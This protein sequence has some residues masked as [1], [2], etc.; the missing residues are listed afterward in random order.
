LYADHPTYVKRDADQQLYEAVRAGE[1]CYVFNCRQMGKSSLQVR[2]ADQLESDGSG[3]RCAVL[4]LS[5]M[6]ADASTAAKWYRTVIGHLDRCLGLLPEQEL[7]QWLTAQGQVMPVY[8][9]QRFIEDVLLV[10]IPEDP[11]VIFIDEIDTVLS[12]SFPANDFFALIRAC[13]NQRSQ[14]PTYRRLTFVLLG[15]A[16]PSQLIRDKTRTPF[17]IGKAIELTPLAFDQAQCLAEGLVGWVADPQRVLA[18]VFEWTGGQPYLTQKLCELVQAEAQEA[19]DL[20]WLPAGQEATEVGRLVQEHLVAHWQN[21]ELPHFKTIQD[22]LLRHAHLTGR[23]LATYEQILQSDGVAVNDSETHG[24]LRLSGLVLPRAGQLQVYNRVYASIFDAG[25]V[26]ATLENLRPYGEAF[27]AWVRSGCRDESRLLRG[28]ALLDA[29]AWAR[30]KSLSELDERF[31]R[32]SQTLE[33]REIQSAMR[34]AQR[35]VKTGTGVLAMMLILAS[36][37]GVF[38]VIFGRRAVSFAQEAAQAKAEQEAA[39]RFGPLETQVSSWDQLSIQL[40]LNTARILQTDAEAK[41]ERAQQQAEAAADE[42]A[43][44]QAQ[45]D[46]AAAANAQLAAQQEALREEREILVAG[47][48]ELESD[49]ARNQEMLALV[50]EGIAIEQDVAPLNQRV[51]SHPLETYLRALEQGFR[52]KARNQELANLRG[53]ASLNDYEVYGPFVLLSRLQN[54]TQAP[55]PKDFLQLSGNNTSQRQT[56][57][58]GHWAVASPDG[59]TI[60]TASGDS[61]AKLWS[62]DGTLLYTLE[63]HQDWV[64]SAVF[65][66]DGQT[67]LTA[68]IDGTARLWSREGTLLTVLEGHQGAVSS[69]IF[70]PDGQLILTASID[71]NARVWNREGTLLNILEGHW[72]PVTSAVFSPDGQHIL[73]AS[74]DGARLWS[75]E[76]TLL[77]I[78]KGHWGPVTSAVFSPDG[79][80]ILTAS[81]NGDTR[82]WS[83]EGTLLNILERH[84]GPVTSA[85]FSSDGQHILT[86]SIDGNAHLWNREGTLLSTL[87][88]LSSIRSA[89]FSPDGQYILTASTDGR[90]RVWS[91]SGQ[92]LDSTGVVEVHSAIFSPDGQYVLT[93]STNGIARVWSSSGQFLDSTGIVEIRSAIFSPDGQYV[94]TTSEDGI[95]RVWS[96]DGQLLHALE[97]L[98]SIVRSAIF[99][100]DG[101]YVLTTSEDGTAKLWSRN[102]N[103]LHS[104]EDHQFAVYSAVFSPDGQPSSP[105]QKTAPPSSGA[106]TATSCTPSRTTRTR[107]PVRSLAPMARPSSPLQKTAP[108]SSGAATATSCTPSRTTSSGSTVRSL[109]PMANHPHRFRRRHRQALEPQRQPPALPRGPPVRGLQCG[110]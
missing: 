66:P 105:L 6:G 73:T 38:A 83:R 42:A 51:E 35:L 76:G 40:S 107:S 60:L 16:T 96:R 62:R 52:L 47:R 33:N 13:F 36:A 100:P 99:S 8:R 25:W 19:E 54:L 15:V 34:K 89:V 75:R 82:L 92:F 101:Q 68:S 67:I 50:Q 46:E 14:H 9:L 26:Q 2:I 24:E 23:L 3:T 102:G 64:N 77:N 29:V 41:A 12:L 65:S 56:L 90:V 59:Q 49:I 5:G 37:A 74:I 18:E 11:I 109:A 28:Q 94:L 86:A 57:F 80:H 21:E 98:Q 17:N 79:Q 70:S 58:I 32:D 108:P 39:V 88:N 87:E 97:D 44:A 95:A 63:G 71:G 106:A 91:S 84:W 10:Q 31:L 45:V 53:Q 85:V 69:A 43:N 30:G 55:L 1:F 27:Q 4:D 78:L 72:G 93:T 48:K 104:L 20:P 61:T 81:D 7:D 22:R 103:L 110:L